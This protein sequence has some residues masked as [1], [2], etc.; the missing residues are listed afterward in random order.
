MSSTT[1]INSSKCACVFEIIYNILNINEYYN[2]TFYCIIN[3][4]KQELNRTTDH[5][6]HTISAA[7][8]TQ[9]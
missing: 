2:I 3:V 4:Y 7:F 1:I 5:N 9:P 6:K 8:P